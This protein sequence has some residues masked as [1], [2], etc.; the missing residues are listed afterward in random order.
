MSSFNPKTT[1]EKILCGLKATA[2][3]RLEKA[4]A[5]AISK[6]PVTVP[7]TLTEDAETH[8]VSGTTTAAFADVKAAYLA[9][10]V[11]QAEAVLPGG[12]TILYA[13]LMSANN[14]ADPTV[15]IF[16]R[17]T[18]LSSDDED[19]APTYIVIAWASNAVMVGTFPLAVASGG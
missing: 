7:F 18:D 19:P 15:F 1:L 14:K 5:A 4:V 16:E 11:L 2:K 9:G 12:E 10:S 17:I 8:V 3:T 6:T 13:P